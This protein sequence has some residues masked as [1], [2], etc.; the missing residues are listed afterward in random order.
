MPCF[1]NIIDKLILVHQGKY[2][3]IPADLGEKAGFIIDCF[4]ENRGFF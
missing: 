1:N 2:R 4:K 3:A